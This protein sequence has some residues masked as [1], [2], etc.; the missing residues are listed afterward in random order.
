MPKNKPVL[1]A[2]LAEIENEL[3]E[4]SLYEFIKQGWHV[5]EP[6]TPFVDGWHIGAICEHLEAV[7][8]GQIRNLLIN[9]A[10]RHMKS[11]IVSVMWPIWEWL[12]W[13]GRRWLTASYSLALAIRDAVKSRRIIE[14]PWFRSRW[15]HVFTLAGDQ[16]VKHRYENDATGYRIA[17]SV[18][19]S[20]TGEGGN[21]VLVD[22]PINAI[23]KDSDKLRSAA[24]TWWDE[25]MST[26]LNDPKRDAKIIIMQRLH[27]SD[28]SGH[29]LRA[30]GYEHLCLPT[31]YDPARRCVTSIGWEDPRTVEGDLLW[32]DRF[33]P[34]E[35]ASAKVAL[36]PMG[37]AGQHGQRPAPAGGGR[38]KVAWLR[39]Y[40]REGD[41]YRLYARDGSLKSVVKVA[42]CDRFSMMD[43]AG[44]EAVDDST[45]AYT[46]VQVWDITPD[47]EMLLVDQ[48]REQCET[49]D[50][51]E[52]AVEIVRRYDCPWIGV[53]KDGIGLGVIQN[54][55]RK[56]I[57]VRPIK[58]RGSKLARSETAEIRAAAGLILIPRG[59]PFLFDLIDELSNFPAGQF[60][61]Q[62]DALAH[63]AIWTHKT[64]GAPTSEAD[65]TH[66][67]EEAAAEAAAEADR[68]RKAERRMIDPLDG[69]EPERRDWIEIAED[70]AAWT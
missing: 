64:R 8:S 53:E 50:A 30:G 19:G 54:I 9:I 65:V 40:D 29:V 12:R 36:G 2:S 41:F 6:A 39:Y 23:D 31:E 13:P 17:T 26:R 47:H 5:V 37:Y 7:T 60:K 20:A 16:N 34:A 45:P 43:P 48:F 68:V 35:N 70:D 62:M 3:A 25:T 21:R 10:P 51:V 38:F 33:G 63:A 58:A 18:G 32:P 28:L 15:G 4:R 52:R 55:K 14:S 61:D 1:I 56:G 59:A 22:D 49:P 66:A 67:T 11:T 42:D 27:E 44:V 24:L 69:E 57:T 46:V